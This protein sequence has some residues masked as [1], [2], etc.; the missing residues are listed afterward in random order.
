VYIKER[1]EFIA[2]Y[3]KNLHLVRQ[4]ITKARKERGDIQINIIKF[5]NSKKRKKTKE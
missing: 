2:I 4:Q 5:F 1:R 3:V